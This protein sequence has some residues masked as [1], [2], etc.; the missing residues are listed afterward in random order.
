MQP[1]LTAPVQ[2]SLPLSL[3]VDGR[4]RVWFS[5]S[6]LSGIAFLD[7]SLA[8]PGTTDGFTELHYPVPPK[9]SLPESD[10]RSAAAPADVMTDRGN[11]LWWAGE[12]GDQI[13]QLH[14]D[15]SQGLRFRGSVRRG[16]TEGPVSDA[17]GNLWVVESGGNLL[18]RISGVT[19]GVLRPF[20]TPAGYEADTTAD[21]V[22]G[23]RLRDTTSVTVRV[24][25]SSAVVATATVPVTDGAFA[26]SG[27]D[28]QG[29]TSDPVRPDDTIRIQPDGPFARAQLSFD[30]AKLAGA[31]RADGAIAGTAL[32]GTRALSD[33]IFVTVGGATGSAPINGGNG[34]WSLV[35]SSPPPPGEPLSL[36]W[37]GANVAGTFRTVTSVAGAPVPQPPAETPG[38]PPPADAPLA[39]PLTPAPSAPAAPSPPAAPAKAA[40][41]CASRHWLY[42]SA[43]R[44]S[45]LLLNL[46]RTQLTACLGKPSTKTAARGT[47]PERWTYGSGL[48]LHLRSGRVRDYTLR[49]GRFATSSRKAGVGSPLADLRRDLPGLRRDAR[50]GLQ[51]AL[52]RRSDGRY[53]DIRV[54]ADKSG[55]IRQIGVTLRARSALDSFG[56]SLLRGKG[57]AA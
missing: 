21:R 3:A 54:R 27:A 14:A 1:P 56:R 55:K 22:S 26:V 7:P 38:T 6:S 20:G 41:P 35:P 4:G 18:T 46:T 25:R 48:E 16:L 2:T 12:Y 37:S 39:Q 30:V 28:W 51:R 34:A 36:A 52:V 23:A 19:A 49:D 17:D 50:S 44:P 29:A 8:D 47:T 53:A 43:T 10:F 45:V 31:V 24:V 42:G 9:Q 32:S 15:G 33:R 40:T 13:E 5:Q 11:N 57:A